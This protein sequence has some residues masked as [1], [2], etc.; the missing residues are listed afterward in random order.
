[1][2]GT[3]NK[4]GSKENYNFAINNGLCNVCIEAKLDAQ[5]TRITELLAE[6]KE[7]K[8]VLG[9]VEAALA[10]WENLDSIKALKEPE[11]HPYWIVRRLV[12]EVAKS[13]DYQKG[14]KNEH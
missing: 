2:R 12:K 8:S 3:C 4:C 6:N 9:H 14:K 1:M 7:L 13:I 5:D 10:Y 11:K